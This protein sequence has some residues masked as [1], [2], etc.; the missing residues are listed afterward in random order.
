MYNN[1][2]ELPKN[3]QSVLPPEAQ[4][5]FR[6]A[7]NNACN[8]YKEPSARREPQVPQE[9]VAFKVAWSAVK[10]VYAKDLHGDW[11]RKK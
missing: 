7:F 11:V 9:T 3:I 1:N 10:K 8:E 4:T 6:K 5:I 2:S